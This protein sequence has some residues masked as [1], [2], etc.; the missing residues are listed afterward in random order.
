[1]SADNNAAIVRRLVKEAQEGGNLGVVDELL[2]DDFVDHTPLPGLP[3]TRDGVRMLF[4]GLRTAF[5]DLRVTIDE[6]IADEEKVATR[7]T[8]R[9]TH[10]GPFMDIPPT[11]RPVAFEAIDIMTVRDG[12]IREHRVVV[13]QLSLMKQLGA[14]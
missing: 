5:P 13:D 2:A 8:F 9:G 3:P 12:R 7:K 14:I 4:A 10:H 11:G 6:Q 1:M